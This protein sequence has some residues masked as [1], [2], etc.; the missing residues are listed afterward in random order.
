MSTEEEFMERVAKL[1]KLSQERKELFE[2]LSDFVFKVLA[3][4]NVEHQEE[5][6]SKLRKALL[7]E[8]WDKLKEILAE[9][10]VKPEKSEENELQ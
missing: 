9:F 3:A 6:R 5:I 8:N 4:E 2:E 1:E 7:A 10:K